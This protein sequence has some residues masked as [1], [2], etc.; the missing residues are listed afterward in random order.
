M[1]VKIIFFSLLGAVS[2]VYSATQTAPP[3]AAPPSLPR[4][5]IAQP[6][7]ADLSS[8]I[9]PTLSPD[10]RWFLFAS[11]K[12]GNYDLWVRPSTG[13]MPYQITNAPSDEYDPVWSPDG[14][15]IYF[16]SNWNDPAG[17]IFVLNFATSELRG[18]KAYRQKPLIRAPGAQSFP[19]VSHNGRFLAFQE[20]EGEN[21]AIVLFDLRKQT[22]RRLTSD[23]FLQPRFSPVDDR[24]LCIAVT[25]DGSGG[26]VCILDCGDLSDPRPEV[27]FAYRGIFPAAMPC[28][29][30]DGNSFVAALVNRDRDGDQR[31]T[32]LDGE[33]L[34]RFDPVDTAF[35]YRQLSLGDVSETHPFI[36]SDG[37]LYYVSNRAGNPDIWRISAEGP[38]PRCSS[39]DEAFQFAL[40]IGAD[41]GLIGKP[42]DRTTLLLRL[43]ALDRVR[44]DFPDDRRTGAKS[45]LESARLLRT[46][47]E[48]EAAESFLK[49][50]LRN[51]SEQKEI[52]A[53][54]LL[55]FI[56]LSHQAE[57]NERG[58]FSINN[59]SSFVA[60]L[61]DFQKSYFTQP[62]SMARSYFLM[63]A[64][65]ESLGD[66]EKALNSYSAVV[67]EY[68]DAEDYP[69][70]ALL[71]TA[72]LYLQLENRDEALQTYLEVIRRFSHRAKPT[73]NAIN[74][75][76]ELQVG[77]EDPIAGLQ[78]LIGG[79]PDLP[80]LTAAAQ[81]RIADYLVQIGDLELALGEY[82]RLRDFSQK[83]PLPFVRL[84][85]AQSLLS[86]A[87]IEYGMGN[88]ESALEKLEEIERDFSELGGGHYRLQ[89]RSLRI[90]FLAARAEEQNR[91]GDAESALA[92]FS[93][94]LVL[95]PE[96]LRLHQGKIA[97]AESSGKL[98]DVIEDYRKA[99]ANHPDHAELLYA[100]GLA[101][102][103][104][105]EKNK[106]NLL[107]SNQ[108]L[109]KA[110]SLRPDLANGYLTL[111]YNFELLE[112]LNRRTIRN[113]SIWSDLFAV[114]GGIL[115]RLGQTISFRSPPLAYQ[116]YEQAIDILQ[117]GLAVNEEQENSRLEA[118]MLLN[119]GNNYFE[120][121]EFGY[122]RALN[123]YLERLR[124][125]STF[126]SNEQEAVIR[127]KI[128][129][130][131]AISGKNDIA[132]QSYQTAI[133][134]YQQSG[135][136]DDELRVMLRLAELYQVQGYAEESNETYRKALTLADREGLKVQRAKLWQ[137]IAF[138]AMEL[139]DDE[140]AA[141][142]TEQALH[143][144]SAANGSRR[145]EYRNPLVLD[146]LGIPIPIRDFGFLG[147][148][149]PASALGFDRTDE[150]LLNYS[151][152]QELSSRKKNYFAAMNQAFRRLDV[153]LQK[154]DWE[155]QANLWSEIG[156][157]Q[158]IEGKTIPARRSFTRSLNLC[159]QYGFRGGRL[160]ALINLAD[161]ELSDFA[162]DTSMKAILLEEVELFSRNE[163]GMPRS[164]WQEIAAV[165]RKMPET[166]KANRTRRY[167]RTTLQKLPDSERPPEELW[168]WNLIERLLML[169]E[170]RIPD[171]NALL[172]EFR[173]EIRRFER[174]PLGFQ[175]ERVRFYELF[176]K[177]CLKAAA[178]LSDSSVEEQVK[179]LQFEAEAMWAYRSGIA[180][181]ERKKL[182]LDHTRLRLDFSDFLF[183]QEEWDECAE[184]LSTA[185]NISHQHGRDDLLW[186]VCWRIGRLL[187]MGAK[188]Q[189]HPGIPE[190]PAYTAE[191]WFSLADEVRN[192]LPDDLIEGGL[193]NPSRREAEVMLWSAF[194]ASFQRRDFPCAA[195]WGQK[196]A[197]LPL[198]EAAR[199]RLIPIRSERRKFV[200]GNGG[201]TVPYLRSELFRIK[202]ELAAALSNQQKDSVSIQTLQ[203]EAENIRQEYDQTIRQVV[204][205]DAEFASLFVNISVSPDTICKTLKPGEAMLQILEFADRCYLIFYTQDTLK[206][207]PLRIAPH[208]DS[209]RF[210]PTNARA[211]NL[212]RSIPTKT[213]LS[214]LFSEATDDL[215]HAFD[216]L[217]LIQPTGCPDPIAVDL[218]SDFG[219]RG[220]FPEILRLPDP[221]SL[222]YLQEKSS[223][224]KGENICFGC[225]TPPAGFVSDSSRGSLG[226]RSQIE[227]AGVVLICFDSEVISNP[228]DR[229]FFDASGN[230]WTGRELFGLDCTGDVLIL[231]GCFDDEILYSRMG[232][233]AGF[234][235]VIFLPENI[236]QAELDIFTRTFLR[237]K[238]ENSPLIA[239][240][241]AKAALSEQGIESSRLDRIRYYGNGGLNQNQKREYAVKNFQR[242][243]LKGN[244][245]LQSG[246]GDWALRYY[247][248]ALAMSRE[249][250]DTVATVNL[251]QLR[252]Q[253][254]RLIQ[255]WEE[256]AVSQR[257]LNRHYERSGDQDELEAGL[258][259]LSVYESNVGN[260]ESA[261][262]HRIQARES[263]ADRG[264]EIQAARD[265]QI[266][267]TLWEKQGDIPRAVSK[268]YEAAKTFRE[269]EEIQPFTETCVY[270]GR[271]H[272]TQ[273]N[274]EKA[275]EVLEQFRE[276][277]RKMIRSIGGDQPLPTE[278]FQHLGAAYEGLMDYA[279]ALDNQL[280]ALAALGDT[281]SLGT[282]LT[283]QYIAGLRWKRGEFQEAI[284]ELQKAREDYD[285]IGKKQY[286]YL[287][288]NIEA[289]IQL[290]LG[291]IGIAQEKGKT[292]LDGAAAAGDEKS[293]LQIEKNLG[294]IDLAANQPEKAKNR[295]LQALQSD[296]ASGT[297]INQALTKL[298]LSNALLQ[299]NQTD[300]AKTYLSEALEIGIST[301]RADIEARALLGLGWIESITGNA[302]KAVELLNQSLSRC[303]E[304]GLDEIAWRVYLRL[305]SVLLR[306]SQEDEALAAFLKA[307][308]IIEQNRITT[309][310][311]GLKS[312]FMEN[313]SEVYEFLAALYWE[314]GD[315]IGVLTA[316]ERA[317]GQELLSH[318]W[319]GQ[320][321]REA[322]LDSLSRRKIQRLNEGI[323]RFRLQKKQ[324][325]K[326]GRS[327]TP[328][329]TNVLRE[330]S[331]KLDSLENEY[332]KLLDEIDLQRPGYR[333][334]VTVPDPNADT[335][336]QLLQPDEAILDFIPVQ[337]SSIKDETQYLILLIK[338]DGIKSHPVQITPD[339]LS[340]LVLRLRNRIHRKLTAAEECRRL[341]QLIISPFHKDLNGIE[342]LILCPIGALMYLSF[343]CLQD[344]NGSDLL[345]QYRITQTHSIAAWILCRQQSSKKEAEKR[346]SVF[347]VG[348]PEASD[349]S[350]RP[351]YV[352]NELRAVIEA[353][354]GSREMSGNE[355]RKPDFILIPPGFNI[356]H[357]AS[358]GKYLPSNPL[359]TRLFRTSAGEKNESL[360]LR[361]VFGL[362]FRQCRLAVFSALDSSPNASDNGSEIS[363]LNEA[364]HYAGV[365]RILSTLWK[366]DDLATAVLIKRFYRYLHSGD[367]P[368]LALQKAQQLVRDR[369]H[370]HPAYWAAFTLYGEAGGVLHQ[371]K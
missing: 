247:D 175:I 215:Q 86:T 294:L 282:A 109:G 349:S 209:G 134:K 80:A 169:Q 189:R 36:A 286:I 155:S 63:G 367:P 179:R 148:G 70:E 191:E 323:T 173:A 91:G 274:Y 289:L 287:L 261:I 316:S 122:P 79:Y 77:G 283:H 260:W 196:I 151:I 157:Y 96:N 264:D 83:L 100:L 139:G 328:A 68:P 331:A 199:T 135:H 136:P 52:G 130:A 8:E 327:Q 317:R 174:D 154:N 144:L 347:A 58:E 194:Q 233:F 368:A 38:I 102:S 123:A 265:D 66:F 296:R 162:P 312:G 200:W 78:Q 270:L 288:D 207:T 53:E 309:A 46:L 12:S 281:I 168:N 273:E 343:S 258:R 243:V 242:T 235:S 163:V 293:R 41:S 359:N 272:I 303:L 371:P 192:Q 60:N 351:T 275:V 129:R 291:N 277:R 125:D 1:S 356:L 18:S 339:S 248:R 357:S 297:P 166:L 21:A 211:A 363:V 336:V 105:A 337:R 345:D 10:G 307:A 67:R 82:A 232:F 360:E 127:E 266:L 143:A 285:R 338:R 3:P 229:V 37:N 253:A 326:K 198:V 149:T 226:Q 47:G 6:L 279:N 208:F 45:F 249:L 240:N 106:S 314:K 142:K 284:Q 310:A 69:A 121:G 107:E 255:R 57:F 263:A 119:L 213:I 27:S 268:L 206:I 236:S 250:Q 108:Y 23:G 152:S 352:R 366:T 238:A 256:A 110:I 306:R 333:H 39:S 49:R 160:S 141:L 186:R 214:L 308:D 131:A 269:W 25:L 117:L 220:Q 251:Y 81:K 73:E 147:T 361:E 362:P 28:W 48:N 276:D 259:N 9:S 222:I 231:I 234:S 369:I 302:N 71:R 203:K 271:L 167:L 145:T 178:S 54:A 204:Q 217:Y 305:G 84:V 114:T 257:I 93:R 201:G 176:A 228:L 301:S 76:L 245:N 85:Y 90:S 230:R 313:Q 113:Q 40:E 126:I 170:P 32:P 171:S 182:S 254:A 20:G 124:F 193:H 150:L 195:Q 221:Q 15:R 42:P 159:N 103:Y 115:R 137:N 241:Q 267:A 2:S 16:T 140:E 61:Y 321:D 89:A 329:E 22:R 237:A 332:L 185:W 223:L 304:F 278:F 262:Q 341:Y 44:S 50:I 116:G 98:A 188:I 128:G 101:L 292:A 184:Q 218:S 190:F 14:K 324:L 5:N 31:L 348:D 205:D 87:F 158:W 165:I 177:L 88:L 51:Y 202:S 318:L 299:V 315:L 322:G 172:G 33:V 334:L 212:R 138:N 239:Y 72:G 120:L 118:Q 97:A 133:R 156:Y 24:I 244:Y 252:I 94:A 95:D 280:Q 132:A 197:S 340:A 344:E 7:T 335:A 346:C 112:K 65:W 370:R 62:L 56:A 17:D 29:S 227:N 153:A 104:A 11:N 34:Y 210:S 183:A 325:L 355:F 19:S 246:D 64:A 225:N 216:R 187:S 319:N 364:F 300:S 219:R 290:D 30:S 358:Q 180:E 354:P 111:G 99:A 320:A 311:E 74:K 330:I 365:P 13:G 92:N 181:A 342:S 146:F 298:D 350:D 353:F 35:V 55:D 224:G 164:R 75:I 4:L 59:P 161:I 43:Q 295:F 26:D